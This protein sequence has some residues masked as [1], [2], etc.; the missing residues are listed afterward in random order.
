MEI[1]FF[2]LFD[3]EEGLL[4]FSLCSKNEKWISGMQL[5]YKSKSESNL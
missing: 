1:F 3:I 2:H 5:V 4:I